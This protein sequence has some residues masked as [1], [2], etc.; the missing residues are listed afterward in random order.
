MTITT[1]R[2]STSTMP[3]GQ[4]KKTHT[5]D[6]AQSPLVVDVWEP[7]NPSHATPILL[8]H[9]WGGTG[10]YWQDTA[11][12]LAQ[13]VTVIV[14]DLP[15]TGR[16]QPVTTAQNLYD[17]VNAIQFVVDALELDTVQLVGHSMG[18]AMS[19]LLAARNPQL[20][21][22]LVLTSLTFFMN[23]A[24]ERVYEMVMRTFKV[25]INF[26]PSWLA[27]VPGV[28]KMMARHYFYNVPDNHQLLQSGLLD[29]LTLD[30]GTALAC[31]QNATDAAIKEAGATIQAPTLMICARQDEMMPLQNV[32]F[33]QDI[34]PDC[35]VRWIENCGHLPMVEKPDAYMA[36]LKDFLV[37]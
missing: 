30:A 6:Y 28:P 37:L 24:Q 1:T 4:V 14:P 17:Q 31:A 7:K 3:Q 16:S 13:T 2:Q 23:K 25:T 34:I 19:V 11:A 26:R 32:D 5:L 33:T 8:V 12:E 29:Y 21:E 15:G 20:V 35:R 22:R 9:G 10:T 27:K 36:I 18:G